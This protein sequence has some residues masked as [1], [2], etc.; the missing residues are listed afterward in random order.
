[1]VL[2]PS[3]DSATCQRRVIQTPSGPTVT[4]IAGRAL[5]P[6]AAWPLRRLRDLLLHRVQRGTVREVFHGD[7]LGAVG[8]AGEQNAGVDR[9]VDQPAVDRLSQDHRA[10][11][12][13]ALGAAL[14]GADGVLGQTKVVEER[15]RRRNVARAAPF[16]LAAG[17]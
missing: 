16:V 2:E 1:L 6:E 17:T 8:L 7:D 11:A 10:G 12:A 9:L 3:R 13:V 5:R 14:F 4:F 15:Q